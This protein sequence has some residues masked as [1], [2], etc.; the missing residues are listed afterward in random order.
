MNS[1]DQN[2]G[3]WADWCS[4]VAA[5]PKWWMIPKVNSIAC[6]IAMAPGLACWA[7]SVMTAPQ[8]D[9]HASIQFT[10]ASCTFVLMCIYSL[11]SVDEGWRLQQ[12]HAWLGCM[13]HCSSNRDIVS[14]NARPHLQHCRSD[15]VSISHDAR[16]DLSVSMCVSGTKMEGE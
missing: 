13:Q 9:K 3:G 8:R 15:R 1:Q 16:P 12:M 7:C 4:L 5:Y 6:A 2:V 11:H 10:Q 14:R